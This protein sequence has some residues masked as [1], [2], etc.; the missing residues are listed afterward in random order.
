[1]NREEQEAWAEV[2]SMG[3]SGIED[4]IKE[5]TIAIKALIINVKLKEDNKSL[6]KTTVKETIEQIP[7]SN[8]KP[9]TPTTG[10]YKWLPLKD[11]GKVR[12]CNNKPCPYFLKYN[13]EKKRY[14][15]GKY[16]PNTEIWT[17]VDDNCDFYGG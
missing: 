16:D 2:I 8:Q 6:E 15:H 10:K 4:V 11:G 17:Y 5:L 3:L 9:T 7:K 14:E 13:D 1:M 12:A